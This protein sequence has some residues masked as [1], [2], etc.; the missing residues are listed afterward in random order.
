MDSN[1]GGPASL[2]EMRVSRLDHVPGAP[3]ARVVLE[4][5]A[6]RSTS[7]TIALPASDAA[8]LV[9]ALRPAGGECSAACDLV[10]APARRLEAAVL[11]AVIDDGPDGVS[12]QLALTHHADRFMLGCDVIDA[13]TLAVRAQA[14][15]YATHRVLDR[16]AV[17]GHGAS[18]CGTAP[19][20]PMP[21]RL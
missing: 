15:I 21:R 19:P 12:A 9:S 4:G 5:A 8:P 16:A 13:L 1:G 14:P 10:L 11:H 18:S 6:N 17:N 2:T 20:E 3:V 7:M